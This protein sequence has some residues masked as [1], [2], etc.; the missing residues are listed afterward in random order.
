MHA[1]IQDTLSSRAALDLPA[2][3]RVRRA[4]KGILHTTCKRTELKKTSSCNNLY[5]RYL[6]SRAHSAYAAARP[7]AGATIRYLVYNAIIGHKVFYSRKIWFKYG[8]YL[9]TRQRCIQDT[10]SSRARLAWRLHSC[11]S[12]KPSECASKG[13]LHTTASA[14]SLNFCL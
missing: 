2:L 11:S 13:F 10:L 3:R 1:C 12:F 6:C 8:F 14:I 5:A 7:G 9:F 4:S